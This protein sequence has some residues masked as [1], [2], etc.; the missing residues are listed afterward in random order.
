MPPGN[1]PCNKPHKHSL[2]FKWTETVLGILGMVGK[3]RI[4]HVP[5]QRKSPGKK[6]PNGFPLFLVGS[7]V[8]VL[9]G[10]LH[11]KISKKQEEGMPECLESHMLEMAEK[12]WWWWQR[13]A[14]PD[15]R[16]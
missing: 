16:Q 9:E 13:S 6:A 1:V 7:L 14:C 8:G 2:Q 5:P 3:N 10:K 11:D 4:M 12:V 15:I